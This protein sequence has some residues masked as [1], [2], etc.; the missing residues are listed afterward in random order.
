MLQSTWSSVADGESETV[1]ATQL[2]AENRESKTASNPVFTAR[3]YASAVYAV[4]VCPS[5][6]GIVSNWLNT[7]SRKQRH[8][9]AR[10]LP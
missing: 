5:H 2:I 3:R 4:V 10:G 9:I 8:M 6:D 7:E 1:I